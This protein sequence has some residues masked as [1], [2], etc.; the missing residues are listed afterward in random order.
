MLTR[1]NFLQA[2]FAAAAAPAICRAESLM[3]LYVP[4]QNIYTGTPEDFLG[5]MDE[6]KVSHEP[7]YD[8]G[9]GDFTIEG[10]IDDAGWKNVTLVQNVEGPNLI[11]TE[12]LDGDRVERGTLNRLNLLR[13][14]AVKANLDLD[15]RI[16]SIDQ[17]FL[18]RSAEIRMTNGVRPK[19]YWLINQ[20]AAWHV[21]EEAR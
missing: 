5:Y 21:I 20:T 9:P 10:W 7:L 6:F 15:G 3:K 14:D 4:A 12:Y 13:A 11:Q 18:I 17:A 8:I 2:M 1:R 16:V 19:D